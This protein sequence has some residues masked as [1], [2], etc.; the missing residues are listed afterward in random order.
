MCVEASSN[1]PCVVA[2]RGDMSNFCVVGLCFLPV[3]IPHPKRED[4]LKR[5][6]PGPLEWCPGRFN[7][8]M[9]NYGKSHQEV[10]SLFGGGSVCGCGEGK[11]QE[12]A[13]NRIICLTG[14]KTQN[15]PQLSNVEPWQP[16]TMATWNHGNL[17]PWQP[18]TMATWNHGNLKP[19]WNHGKVVPWSQ[20]AA[21]ENSRSNCCDSAASNRIRNIESLI[22]DL[23]RTSKWQSS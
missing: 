20:R 16:G 11:Q 6:M 23:H 18:G 8:E 2:W 19:T 12:R 5:R 10:H 7:S 13:G 22:T 14:W 15:Q 17:E 3:K 9:A 1:W 21:T 4:M